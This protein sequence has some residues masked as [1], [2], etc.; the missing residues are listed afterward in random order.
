MPQLR[1]SHITKKTYY[2]IP[3][4]EKDLLRNTLSA[5]VNRSVL[6]YVFGR[7]PNWTVVVLPSLHVRNGNEVLGFCFTPQDGN[8]LLSS[9]AATKRMLCQEEF[10]ERMSTLDSLLFEI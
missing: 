7:I 5:R 4:Y 3:Y 10:H 2:V 8:T 6:F 9:I 1:R